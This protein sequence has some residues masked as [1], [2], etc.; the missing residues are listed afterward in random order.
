MRQ[1]NLVLI[2][3][4]KVICKSSGNCKWFLFIFYIAL[5]LFFTTLFINSVKVKQG[6]CR[7][8]PEKDLSL[9]LAVAISN[10]LLKSHVIVISSVPRLWLWILSTWILLLLAYKTLRKK[11]LH[12]LPCSGSTEGIGTAVNCLFLSSSGFVKRNWPSSYQR[13]WSQRMPQSCQG[14]S[15]CLGSCRRESGRNVLQRTRVFCCT[16]FKDAPGPSNANSLYLQISESRSCT[17]CCS[18]MRW[19][20]CFRQKHSNVCA[21]I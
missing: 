4:M 11:I 21:G 13:T 10:V 7:S 5:L 15:F 14:N 2:N 18:V 12:T 9:T 17:Q 8:R 1:S 16:S 3:I 20:L 19:S 6:Q